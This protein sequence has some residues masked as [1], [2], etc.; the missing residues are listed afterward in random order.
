MFAQLKICPSHSALQI[1]G[2][3]HVFVASIELFKPGTVVTPV[4]LATWEA[5]S[6]G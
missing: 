4:I 1:V 2:T 5:R 6:G 3:S